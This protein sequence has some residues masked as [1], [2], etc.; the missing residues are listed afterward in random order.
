MG[1]E[2]WLNAASEGPLPLCAKE[3]L[4]AVAEK[5]CRPYELTFEYFAQVPLRLKQSLGRLINVPFRD[6]ILAN[7]A[8]YGVHLIAE[9]TNWNADDEVVLMQNDFPTNILP[10]LA[11]T[12]Q[13]VNVKQVKAERYILSL[14]ELNAALTPK[15]RVVCLSHVHTFSG[16]MLNDVS[17][18]AEACHAAGAKLIINISQ[19]CGN[20]SIDVATMGVDAVVCAGYKWLLGPYGIGFCWIDPAWRDSLEINRA[21]WASQMSEDELKSEDV[22]HYKDIKSARKYDF[23]GTANFF[24]NVPFTASVEM[25]LGIGVDKVKQYNDALNEKLLKQ[26]DQNKFEIISP[27]DPLKRSALTVLSLKD[28]KHNPDLFAFLKGQKLHTALWKNKIRV[29]PHIYNTKEDID[30]L[31]A[32]LNGYDYE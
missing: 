1:S 20:C 30:R 4:L 27:Q 24:N 22:L 7:S 9:G 10:W 5:K 31:T 23:F 29:T 8:S 11:L 16:H 32:A 18:Y 21:Y 13:G 2:T 19:S 12:K 14:D 17:E 15:T 25:L 6:I 3:A 26:I 28:N